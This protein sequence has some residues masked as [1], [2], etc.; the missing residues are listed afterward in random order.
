MCARTKDTC[1]LNRTI[2]LELQNDVIAQMTESG[3]SICKNDNN[4][5]NLEKMNTVTVRL[6]DINQHKA[7][8]KFLDMCFRKGSTVVWIFKFTD[9]VFQN[10]DIPWENSTSLGVYNTFVKVGR[11]DLSIVEARKMN[12]DIFLI[13][14]PCHIAHNPSKHNHKKRK[15]SLETRRYC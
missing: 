6:L 7:L 15:D 4:N 12:S 1:I 3:Y 2:K 11:H 14:C 8:T 9:N 10:Y 13:G 5:Q